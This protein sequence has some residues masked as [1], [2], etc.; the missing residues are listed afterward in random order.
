MQADARK[1]A[2]APATCWI[3]H[4]TS[5]HFPDHSVSGIQTLAFTWTGAGLTP[6]ACRM[7]G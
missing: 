2:A 3:C 4:H 1:G 7:N 5:A 6:Y